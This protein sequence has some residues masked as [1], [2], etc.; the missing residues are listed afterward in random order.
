VFSSFPTSAA[1]DP[2]APYLNGYPLY[3]CDELEIGCRSTVETRVNGVIRKGGNPYS[4]AYA[5]DESSANMYKYR[6]SVR[7]KGFFSMA[8][9][10]KI[11]LDSP[12]ESQ[13]EPAKDS[14][15]SWSQAAEQAIDGY[16]S[17]S[18]F[19]SNYQFTKLPLS[20]LFSS[21]YASAFSCNNSDLDG[22]ME[23]AT[24]LDFATT[25]ALRRQFAADLLIP[26]E[27]TYSLA[28]ALNIFL[29]VVNIEKGDFSFGFSGLTFMTPP[30]YFQDGSHLNVEYM[31][32][33]Q[34][35]A[36]K[37]DSVIDC[38]GNK[39]KMDGSQH[40]DG[41]QFVFS[42]EESF[43]DF[44]AHHSY[45]G[46]WGADGV[47]DRY[48]PKICKLRIKHNRYPPEAILICWRIK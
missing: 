10:F 34:N 47:L 33:E 17:S 14:Y 48:N 23:T 43:Q 28:N 46:T 4:F 12:T 35:M 31:S 25:E 18:G 7:R 26:E 44:I 1:A 27:L 3:I 42:S 15:E 45:S 8:S 5:I 9:A 16:N 38:N 36:V 6:I 21:A 41:E 24:S 20:F 2:S 40:S 19:M 32:Y 29:D 39:I 22:T 13:L 11:S 37:N 30:S